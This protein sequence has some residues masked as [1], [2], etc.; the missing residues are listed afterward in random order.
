M[1]V[2]SV[3][4]SSTESFKSAVGSSTGSFNFAAIGS[5]TNAE[6]LKFEADLTVL[7]EA[8]P[9]LDV[10]D[11]KRLLVDENGWDIKKLLA[12]CNY[13][14]Y[15]KENKSNLSQNEESASR[16][17]ELIAI[18]EK[19]WLP[20]KLH[21]DDEIAVFLVD[22]LSAIDS[23]EK[24]ALDLAFCNLKGRRLILAYHLRAEGPKAHGFGFL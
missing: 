7:K 21:K 8:L 10:S 23:K 17:N 14:K 15:F 1:P 11:L 6:R 3:V 13:M 18:I 12:L 5:S 19:G 2:L 22:C 9:T 4:G 24:P 20:E 16:K